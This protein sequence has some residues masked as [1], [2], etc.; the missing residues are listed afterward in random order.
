MRSRAIAEQDVRK[1]HDLRLISSAAG[2]TLMVLSGVFQLAG[3]A[4]L[5]HPGKVLFWIA[6]ATVLSTAL[7]GRL[8]Q[9]SRR[10]LQQV[11]PLAALDPYE[12]PRG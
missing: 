7:T 11:P 3:D 5:R 4:S 1:W 12:D 6:L 8:E 9:A 2:L 10:R